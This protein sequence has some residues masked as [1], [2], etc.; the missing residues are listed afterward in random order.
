MEIFTL[1]PDSRYLGVNL[2]WVLKPF[3]LLQWPLTCSFSQLLRLGGCSFSRLLSW[4]GGDWSRFAVLTEIQFSVLIPCSLIAATFRLISSV[5]EKSIWTLFGSVFLACIEGWSLDGPHSAISEVLLAC[6]L[7]M[8]VLGL[9][10]SP[11]SAPAVFSSVLP[12][13]VSV[14]RRTSASQLPTWAP[15][16]GM[17]RQVVSLAS[18]QFLWSVGMTP[19]FIWPWADV[20]G[21][22]C[23]PPLEG[24]EGRK[25]G[26]IVHWAN[27]WDDHIIYYLN[28]DIFNSKKYSS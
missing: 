24:K 13:F 14:Q 2:W 26:S 28:W 23:L 16:W 20:G 9:Q 4:E 27:D 10:A 12:W 5:P 22:T 3:C 11:T 8:W 18:P 25:S 15:S 6:I 21:S 17:A 7:D 19:S 1:L